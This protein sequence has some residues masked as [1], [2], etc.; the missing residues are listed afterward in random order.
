MIGMGAF[1]C[2]DLHHQ[3]SI[4]T[5]VN[6]KKG[7]GT[8]NVNLNFFAADVAEES[9]AKIRENPENVREDGT[10]DWE[11]YNESR[12]G[13]AMRKFVASGLAEG[14]DEVADLK[15]PRLVS[16]G[17]EH[18]LSVCA[19]CQAV[20]RNRSH[21]HFTSHEDHNAKKDENEKQLAKLK[22]L[23]SE[24]TELAKDSVTV[25]HAM[26]RTVTAPSTLTQSVRA[27]LRGT[28]VLHQHSPPSIPGSGARARS[29]SR[30][31][32][33]RSD[34]ITVAEQATRGSML[35]ICGLR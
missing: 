8:I 33:G 5:V 15:V 30:S 20:K 21:L 31:A 25:A 6:L 34:G 18:V 16:M 13:A 14:E 35:D 11:K 24:T 29:T 7:M 9:E 28:I 1:S 10:I 3:Q 17:G 19:L 2:A 4:D 23:A 27:H 26:K 22:A 32:V 12:R